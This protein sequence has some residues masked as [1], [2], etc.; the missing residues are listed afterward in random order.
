MEYPHEFSGQAKMRVELEETR[1]GKD[2][3]EA[4]LRL[5]WSSCGPGERLEELVREYI[6]RIWIVFVEEACKLA[7]RHVW[8]LARVKGTSL[9]FLSSLTSQAILEKGYDTGGTAYA[10]AVRRIRGMTSHITGGILPQV[11]AKFEKS[12][13]CQ[14]YQDLLLRVA[15]GL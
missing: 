12:A 11:M 14:K 2:L 9:E 13:H 4:R 3:D 8:D 15:G 7:R 5:P 1:A 10:G 6:L